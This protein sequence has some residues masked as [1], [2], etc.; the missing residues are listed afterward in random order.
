MI[1]ILI[2]TREQRPWSLDPSRFA[3]SRATLRTGDYTIAGLEDRFVVERKSLGDFVGTVIGDWIRFR[4]ELYR[5]AA[6]DFAVIVVEADT[7]DV[8]AHRYESEANPES[9]IGRANA[10]YLDHGVPVL[11]WGSRLGGC[12][13]MAENLFAMAAKKL[14]VPAL[15]PQTNSLPASLSDP[16]LSQPAPALSAVSR[17]SSR[18]TRPTA[19]AG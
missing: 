13:H 1:P 14:G 8:F 4:K 6:F 5:L 3:T 17:G 15:C 11:W 19:V 12:V 2:D 16:V 18:S 7:A 10:I 9:V